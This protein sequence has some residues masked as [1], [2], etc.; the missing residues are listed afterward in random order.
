[1]AVDVPTVLV[2]AGLSAVVAVFTAGAVAR[3]KARADRDLAGRA[4]VRTAVRP[5]RQELSLWA[6]QGIVER[7]RGRASARDAEVVSAILAVVDDLPAWRRPLV[8]RRLRRLFGHTWVRYSELWPYDPDNP[9][10]TLIRAAVY[11]HR[12]GGPTGEGALL[13]S[14]LV[15]RTLSG[16]V[17]GGRPAKRLDGELRRL[18][19]AR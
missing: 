6:Y 17:F 14:G 11:E 1:M 12:V 8:R 18:S 15:H 5:L 16:D 2:S 7:E 3:V 4:A 9:M 10:N 13:T 19:A